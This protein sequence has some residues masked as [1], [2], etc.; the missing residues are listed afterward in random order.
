VLSKKQVK[1]VKMDQIWAPW[2]MEFI[3]QGGAHECFLCVKPK[4][5]FDEPNYILYRGKYNFILLNAYPYNPGHLLVAPYRHI[6]SLELTEELELKEH[7]E[8]VKQCVRLLGNVI[9]PAGFNIGMNLGRIAG[10]GLADH[11][12][13]HVVPRWQGDTNFMPVVAETK[14]L[15]EALAETYRKLHGCFKDLKI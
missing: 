2:R 9:K 14:V 4:E 11:I 5:N 3:N 13:S 10:A 1:E 6:N 8:L 7:H 15:S 12:H